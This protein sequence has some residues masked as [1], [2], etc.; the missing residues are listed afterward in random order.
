MGKADVHIHSTYSDG[1]ASVADILAHVQ[2]H[3]DLD[4]IAITDHDCIDG[5]LR[6]RELALHA[7]Y[8]FQVMIGVE[9]STRDGHLLALEVERPVPAGMGMADTIAAVH[10]QG[11]IAIVA[12]PLS[13]LC[14]S[15]SLSVLETLAATA[16]TGLVG[17]EALNGSLAALGSS[18][19]VRRLNRARFAWPNLGGSDAHTLGA[20]GCSHTAFPGQTRGALREAIKHDRVA[21][22]GGMWPA[23]EMIRYALGR[24]RWPRAG[25]DALQPRPTST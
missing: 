12:H 5:A 16:F 4:V 13:R 21:A 23:A 14:P 9:V 24:E 6:A 1:M 15:A 22:A 17:L 2:A 8:R 25:D 3:T 19:R 20:I 10:E 18:R 7:H 11:G